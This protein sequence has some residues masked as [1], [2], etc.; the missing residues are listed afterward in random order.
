M[1]LESL[2]EDC[3]KIEK[4]IAQNEE[5]LKNV[6]SD[7]TITNKLYKIAFNYFNFDTKSP[8]DKRALD[9][10]GVTL[11]NYK[12]PYDCIATYIQKYEN[13]IS[14]DREKLKETA[15]TLT[16]LEKIVAGT[17]VQSLIEEEKQRQQSDWI[18]NGLKTAGA[19]TSK[20]EKAAE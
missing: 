12:Q 19:N 2:Q 7:T 4:R 9:E 15:D 1:T 14:E 16:L 5:H 6:K 17:Y 18:P 13:I 20:L 3:V 8:Q 10:Y 11:D